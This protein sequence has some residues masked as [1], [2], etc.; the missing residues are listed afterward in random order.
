MGAVATE[1]GTVVSAVMLGAVAGS[2]LFPFRARGLRSRRAGAAAA[3]ARRPAC[4]A[5]RKAFDIVANGRH[6]GLRSGI[7]VGARTMALRVEP[8]MTARRDSLSRH[9]S[10]TCWPSAMPACWSTRARP[11]RSLPGAP[12]ASAGRPSAPPTRRARTDF[13]TTREMARWLAL[14]MAFDD[15]VRVADLKSRDRA[16]AARQGRSQGRRGRPAQGLRPLQAR[17]AGIRRAAAAGPGLAGWCAGTAR[18]CARA[19][20]RGPCR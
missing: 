17:R 11:T 15:I 13:A 12:A 4:A 14:W 20:S 7:H 5:L 9:R 6:A 19:S 2:G 1:A 16:L 10:T 18:A 3:R 8:A